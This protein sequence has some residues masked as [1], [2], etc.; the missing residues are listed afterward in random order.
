MRFPIL[1]YTSE[2]ILCSTICVHSATRHNIH[3][4]QC[5]VL[6]ISQFQQCPCPPPP[7]NP[8]AFAFFLE[9]MGELPGMGTHELCKCPGVGTNKEDKCPAPEIVVDRSALKPT[10]KPFNNENFRRLKENFY[11]YKSALGLRRMSQSR[12][13]WQ[14][15]VFARYFFCEESRHL[16]DVSSHFKLARSVLKIWKIA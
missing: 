5:G 15:P 8:R 16:T 6:C 2:L 13:G 4:F 7:A 10:S 14:A 3:I 11:K 12:E 1:I 9:K